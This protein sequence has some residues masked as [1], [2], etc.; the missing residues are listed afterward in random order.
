MDPDVKLPNFLIVGAAKCGT[1][2]LHYLLSKNP[3]IFMAKQKELKFFCCPEIDKQINGKGAS[4][5]LN[6][7]VRCIN[8]YK[9]HFK[10]AASFNAV[11]EISPHYLY[12]YTNSIKRIHKHLGDIPIFIILR[13]PV[14]RAFSLYSHL[15]RDSREHRTFEN[16]LRLEQQNIKNNF[17]FI[18]HFKRSGFYYNQVKAYKDQFSQVTVYIYEDWASNLHGLANAI[19][20]SLGLSKIEYT[21]KAKLNI[22]GIPRINWLNDF[23]NSRL[24]KFLQRVENKLFSDSVLIKN[25]RNSNLEKR[26]MD[27]ATKVELEDF[28]KK[29]VEKL[30]KYLEI[31]LSEKWFKK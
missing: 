17:E 20:E 5:A 7:R 19:S 27:S 2:T 11:G 10:D 21:E 26:Y 12:Y 9:K 23:Y 4:R 15:R 6:N 16:V 31:N 1:T 28:F 25:L 24:V 14:D 30:S 22:S 13:N 18:W 29:D 8:E 3:D